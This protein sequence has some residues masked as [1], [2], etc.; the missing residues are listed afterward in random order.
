MHVVQSALAKLSPDFWRS[1]DPPPSLLALSPF[2]FCDAVAPSL[3][4][5][6]H[7]V[8]RRARAVDNVAETETQDRMQDARAPLVPQIRAEFVGVFA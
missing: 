2:L 8:T 1:H 3:D 5:L 7:A 4:P 6:E